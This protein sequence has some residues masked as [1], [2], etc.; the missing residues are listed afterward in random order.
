MSANL[1]MNQQ[2]IPDEDFMYQALVNRDSSLEGIFYF[3][4]RTTGIFCRPTCSAR[5]PRKEN[6]D[7]FDSVK[8][9]LDS[10]YRPCK[11]CSPLTK[12]GQA[13]DWLQQLLDEVHAA[14]EV[15]FKD[16][17]LQMRQLD[18][19]RVRRWFQKHHGMTFQAYLRALRVNRAFEKMKN[20][21]DVTSTA[22]DSGYQSLSGFHA[23]FSDATGFSP[24]QSRNQSLV[25]ITRLSTPLGQM[26]AGANEQGLC[27]LEFIDR[28]MIDD[29]IAQLQKQLQARFVTGVNRHLSALE[30]QLAEYFAGERHHFDIALDVRGSEFQQKAWQALQQ[31]PYGE[32]RSY[33]QQAVAVGNA[34]A[35]RAIASANAKNRIA[36]VIPCHR[37]IAK[38]GGL[39]GFGG[40]VWRK[41][42][43]LDLEKQKRGR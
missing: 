41:K 38:D 14:P 34:K 8:S 17:D 32:T 28:K 2:T 10:G 3:G 35:V 43:L 27:L 23:A 40:G 30:V 12:A 33:A 18:P 26:Y 5:K 21:Q 37:V 24:S 29:Q 16:E 36:I 1:M 13:P 42:Y 4:V 19:V 22:F 11:I 15:S 25:N 31:I 39:A 9:A 20:S 7:Y 6:V